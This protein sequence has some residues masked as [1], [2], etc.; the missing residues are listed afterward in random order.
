MNSMEGCRSAIVA[1]TRSLGI[2]AIRALSLKASFP[3]PLQ[4]NFHNPCYHRFEL[5]REKC[6][7]FHC[8]GVP[9]SYRLSIGYLNGSAVGSKSSFD[10]VT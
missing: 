2:F 5:N 9:R 10:V 8:K 1:R 3:A 7:D 4:D 6:V